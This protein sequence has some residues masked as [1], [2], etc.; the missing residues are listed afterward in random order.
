MPKLT[1]AGHPL[2][3]QLIAAP[4]GLLPFSFGMDLMHYATGKQSYADAAF[5]SMVGGYVGGAAAGVAGAADYLTIPSGTPLKKTANMHG[6]LNLMVM[7]LYGANLALR[8]GRRSPGLLPVV[9]SALG[10]AGLVVSQWYGGRMVY[11]HGMRV[12]GADPTE[13]ARE[14]K[15]PGDERMTHA[16]SDA[17]RRF[18]PAGRER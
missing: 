3:P 16:L 14:L 5:Y 12:E 9:L 1:F 6:G 4:I 2:H 13:G 17:Q 10:T 18:A 7:G 8:R 15:A 11:E